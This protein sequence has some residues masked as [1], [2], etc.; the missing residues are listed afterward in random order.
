MAPR[1]GDSLGGSGHAT[2]NAA[3]GGSITLER[4]GLVGSLLQGKE[5]TEP[6]RVDG[7]VEYPGRGL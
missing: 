6:K 3:D 4:T 2:A 1:M 7:V 5:V